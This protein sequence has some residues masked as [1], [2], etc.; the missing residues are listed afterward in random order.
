[1]MS[2]RASAR[3]LKPPPPSDWIRVGLGDEHAAW[4]AVGVSD[5]LR[6]A[7]LRAIGVSPEDLFRLPDG[8][9]IGRAFTLGYLC[10][11]DVTERLVGIEPSD[12]VESSVVRRCA[13]PRDE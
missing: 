13:Q 3:R 4:M 6:A 10:V 1:M 8:R 11:L 9:E 5:P 12:E 7:L 2:G